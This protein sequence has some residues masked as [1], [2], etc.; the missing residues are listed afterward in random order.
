MKGSSGTF[1]SVLRSLRRNSGLSQE[2]LAK[3][4][5]VDF[6]YISKLENDRVRPPAEET[7]YR[8]CSAL[9]AN[10]DELLT[11]SKKLPEQ[12]G[13][14]MASSRPALEFLRKA[15]EMDLSEG[16]WARMTR[17]LRRLRK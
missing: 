17:E 9:Q 4:A 3:L 12:V 11:A 7:I 15:Q 10:A 2:E 13:T 16:E 14:A 1:G 6:T 8:I 5:G